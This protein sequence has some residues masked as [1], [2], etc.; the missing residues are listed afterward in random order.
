MYALALAGAAGSPPLCRSCVRGVQK[1][2]ALQ[3]FVGVEDQNFGQWRN[4]KTVG[5]TRVV[6][7]LHAART[8]IIGFF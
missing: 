2:C 7:V 5:F 1:H 6:S 4:A 8:C 3:G